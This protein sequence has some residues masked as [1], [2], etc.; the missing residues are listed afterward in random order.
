MP[1]SERTVSEEKRRFIEEWQRDE[2]SFAELCRCYGVSRKTGYELVERYEAEGLAGL[3]PRS[4]APHRHPNAVPETITSALLALRHRHPKWGAKKLRAYLEAR[5]PEVGW[6]VLS[7][8]NELLDRNGLLVRRR[9]RRRVPPALTGLSSCEASNDV[10]GVDF[11]GWFRTL[12]GARCEPLS[13]SDLHSR[14]VLRLQGLRRIDGAQVWP[15]LDAAF[16][17]FG[18]P[19]TIRSDNGA[20]F[21]SIGVGGLSALSVKLIKAGVVPERIQPGKPQQNGRHERLHRTVAEETAAPPAGNLRAQQRR[22]DA[23]CREFNEERPHEALGLRPPASVFQP[24]P[25]TWNR[26]LCEP[27]YEAD[28]LVRRVRHNGEIKWRGALV[29]LGSALAGEPV[30]ITEIAAGRW[31]VVYGPILLGTLDD[32][33]NF[34]RPRRGHAPTAGDRPDLRG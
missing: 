32:Q 29:F 18:L 10:W 33:A 1:W 20:P 9:V 22:F 21:A 12:D 6:P 31:R 19:R 14:Y 28:Q 8:I 25:R 13:L 7:T 26:R 16:C 4:R 17:E 23:F 5:Q 34:V 27:E 11:K 2:M 30:S 24:S 3:K 15:I